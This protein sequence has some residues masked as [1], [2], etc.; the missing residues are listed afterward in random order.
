MP[1]GFTRAFAER[2]D[3]ES[4][5]K[6]R[7]AQDGDRVEAGH[8]LVA[9]GDLHL[10]LREDLHGYFAEV[11]AGPLVSRH[12]PSVDVLFR[13]V[14]EL[15]GPHSVGV[16]LTGMGD[17][18]AEGLLAMRRAGAATLVQDEATS[19]VFGMPKEA[20]RRGATEN[21]LPLPAISEAI[22]SLVTGTLARSPLAYRPTERQRASAAPG[23]SS[24][25]RQH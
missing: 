24:V 20:I 6:V 21:V 16:L 25:L 23:R 14:A 8:A 3:Q 15:A 12:R 13:S 7:E 5:L 2:L 9:P 17:D 11:T 18:G 1:A 10:R 22:R 19:V 4:A